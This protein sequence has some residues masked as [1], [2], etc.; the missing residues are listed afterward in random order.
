MSETET[1][2]KYE[3]TKPHFKSLLSEA[4]NNPENT[5]NTFYIWVKIDYLYFNLSPHASYLQWSTNISNE[6][7]PIDSP[8]NEPTIKPYTSF[9]SVST[10]PISSSSSEVSTS[11]PDDE[12]PLVDWCNAYDIES[13]STPN[14]YPY[15]TV[16]NSKP[17]DETP[18]V[19]CYNNHDT[20]ISYS[21]SPIDS[22]THDSLSGFL[23]VTDSSDMI[24]TAVSHIHSFDSVLTTANSYSSPN[25]STF[26]LD[27]ETPPVD[28][29]NY[30]DMESPCNQIEHISNFCNHD[31][32]TFNFN[33]DDETISM[34]SFINNDIPREILIMNND[35]SC[36]STYY[37]RSDTIWFE[38]DA[39]LHDF[40]SNLYISNP[41]PPSIVSNL[42]P[43]DATLSLNSFSDDGSL[44]EVPI[45]D[46]D[47]FNAL[48]SHQDE[49][50][51][52]TTR[53]SLSSIISNQYLITLTT[54]ITLVDYCLYNINYPNHYKLNYDFTF[55]YYKIII[56]LSSKYDDN[57]TTNCTLSS[58]TTFFDWEM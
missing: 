5:E 3:I 10:T 2:E 30:H 34:I 14:S 22:S 41:S 55:K 33:P 28:C 25:V 39:S 20:E 56:F 45:A 11:N 1:S 44:N 4:I 26:H 50:H 35:D 31:T 53:S 18:L 46:Y 16:L 12:T 47:D 49:K 51:K 7:F 58:I 23:S 52:S 48:N 43:H 29:C 19:D 6:P 54:N 17:D 27:N 36:D 38:S 15:S 24:S 40:N 32:S 13:S 21:T 57:I 42:N 37:E 9:N 8:T